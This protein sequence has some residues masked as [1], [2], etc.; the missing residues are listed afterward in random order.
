MMKIIDIS[1]PISNDMVTYKD[2]GDV[3]IEATRTFERDGGRE[4]KLTCGTHT[5]THV[6][7][8]AH[9]LK[10]GKTLDQMDLSQ[11]IGKCALIDMTHITEKIT[12]E[13]LKDCDLQD[14]KIVLFKTKNSNLPAAGKFDLNFIYL[15][16][17]GAEF[18][19]QKNL[20]AVGIDSLGIER[21]QPDHDTHKT[22]FNS[23]A[24]IIEG[25]R[26]KNVNPDIYNLVCLPLNIVGADGAPARA[27][28]ML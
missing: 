11:L 22:L 10:E 4:S 12:A 7:A 26:L 9:F 23:G 28:L 25:L 15:D 17:T 1:W 13:D 6:D 21:N 2:K 27:V 20:T 8:P 19:A 24:L 18:L 5:G 14:C 16:K 3:K